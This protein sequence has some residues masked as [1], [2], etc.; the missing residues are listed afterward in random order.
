MCLQ[1]ASTGRILLA[2]GWPSSC[3]GNEVGP[4]GGEPAC[5]L[6]PVLFLYPPALEFSLEP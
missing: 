1:H 2:S 5:V 3:A 4:R 6:H